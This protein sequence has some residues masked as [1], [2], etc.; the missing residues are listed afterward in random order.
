MKPTLQTIRA[1]RPILANVIEQYADFTV[2]Q[3]IETFSRNE[4]KPIQP[5]TD[6]IDAAASYV[7]QLLGSDI[8][9]R[10]RHELASTP[11]VLTANHHCPDYLSYTVQGS[12][13]FGLSKRSEGVVPVFAGGGIPLDNAHYPRGII[14]S[15]GIRINIFPEK[16]KRALVSTVYP[17][18]I[19]MIK[20]GQKQIVK[21]KDAARISETESTALTTILEEDYLSDEALQQHNYSDQ[22]SVL[23]HRLWRRLYAPQLQD[24]IPDMV[25]LELEK[26]TGTLLAKD[27]GRN[28]TLMHE[29]LFN[30]S[31][32]NATIRNL[33]KIR[34]CWHTKHLDLL[35]HPRIG[36]DERKNLLRGSGTMFFWGID[37]KRRRYPLVLQETENI[38]YLKGFDD[39]GHPHA[40]A[41]TPDAIVNGL[42][43]GILL[44]S[45]FTDFA[46]I[47]F[48]RGFKCYGGFM[49]TD[50][51]TEMKHG[52]TTAMRQEGFDE[53]AEKVGSVLTD[54]YT[55][56]M[57]F[58]VSFTCDGKSQP[59]GALN[60]IKNG[61]L[62]KEELQRIKAQKI[63]DANLRGLHDIYNVIGKETEDSHEKV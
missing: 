21:L 23:N 32:R 63:Y 29:I 62:T 40:V 56:G 13:L 49:Q 42:E 17:F 10:L 12:I 16:D 22:A 37:K 48:A 43:T 45:L 58:I 35:A 2:E 6:F 25:Y 59:A 31:L 52:L 46:I 38:M 55:T 33:D 47:A 11:V 9:N 20:K 3:Y 18:T 34:G 50:Y 51:L 8:A 15:K 26:I 30:P 14:T 19:N 57:I 44:P 41:Y 36:K 5:R 24:E 61:G 60:I 53:W 4:A 7:Q 1:Q 28:G 27:I 39:S 54:N